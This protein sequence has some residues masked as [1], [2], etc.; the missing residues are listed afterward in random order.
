ME[1]ARIDP[2]DASKAAWQYGV[3]RLDHAEL[4]MEYDGKEVFEAPRGN[5]LS[6]SDK[7]YWLGFINTAPAPRPNK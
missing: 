4:H 2:K 6:G 5:R 7:S 3:G 1:L